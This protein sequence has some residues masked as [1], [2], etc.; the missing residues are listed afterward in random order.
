MNCFSL[1][2]EKDKVI[3]AFILW[4]SGNISLSIIDQILELTKNSGDYKIF[5]W[6]IDLIGLLLQSKSTI[7]SEKNCRN[8]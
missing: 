7:F 4:T 6:I 1:L 5:V 8:W 3:T 2:S